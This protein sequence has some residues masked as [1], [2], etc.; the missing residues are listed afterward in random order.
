MTDYADECNLEYQRREEEGEKRRERVYDLTEELEQYP[1]VF[2]EALKE[3]ISEMEDLTELH[4]L[5]MLGEDR[6]THIMRK[7]F[8]RYC[9]RLAEE[10]SDET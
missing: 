5:V 1:E 10:Q 4:R 2:R 9:K 3:S 7:D 6:A 8:R